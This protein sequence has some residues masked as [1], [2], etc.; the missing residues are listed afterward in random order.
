MWFAVQPSTNLRTI[1]AP[2]LALSQCGFVVYQPLTTR[3]CTSGANRTLAPL[4]TLDFGLWT[5][6]SKPGTLSPPTQ[7]HPNP[8]GVIRGKKIM[9]RAVLCLPSS[10][11]RPLPHP[12]FSGAFP[13]LFRRNPQF[14]IFL[15]RFLMILPSM[16]LPIPEYAV[17]SLTVTTRYSLFGRRDRCRTF[18][19]GAT[20]SRRSFPNVSTSVPD[21]R[22][23]GLPMWQNRGD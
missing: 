5:Q 14:S 16:I 23:V 19:G 21:G 22:H 20:R 12:H 3:N 2:F 18:G 6:N 8:I 1:S 9:R 13:A 4:W 17:F 11:L 10:V 15:L 7:T